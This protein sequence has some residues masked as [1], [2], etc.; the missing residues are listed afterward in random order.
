[1]TD[2]DIERLATVPFNEL[3]AAEQW[4]LVKQQKLAEAWNERAAQRFREAHHG[5]DFTQVPPGVYG[6][7]KYKAAGQPSY[8]L[9][10]ERG[11]VT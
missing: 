5:K 9:E 8:K 1:M 2:F 10:A 6:A 4:E 11:Y 7:R 3:T